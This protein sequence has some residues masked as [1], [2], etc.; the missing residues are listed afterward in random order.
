MIV[1]N[2]VYTKISPEH[3]EQRDELGDL[4]VDGILIL[5]WI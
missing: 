1:S 3:L 4:E 2:A 5:K